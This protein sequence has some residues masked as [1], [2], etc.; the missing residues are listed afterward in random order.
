MHL[1][2]SSRINRIYVVVL[3]CFALFMVSQYF[4]GSQKPRWFQQKSTTINTKDEISYC[5]S[6]SGTSNIAIAVKT[7]A[8]EAASKIP[9][10]MLTSL[11]CA[12]DVMI[13]SDLE[14]TIAGFHLHDALADIPLSAMRGNPDFDFYWKLK[15]ANR[16]GQIENMLKGVRDPRM[17][18]ELAAWT[19][20]KYKFLHVLEKLYAEY[21]NKDWYLLM[22]ADTYVVWPNLVTWLQQLPD[23]TSNK[24]YLGN[25][26]RVK[27]MYFA[28]GGSG[29]LI[30]RAAMYEFAVTNNGTASRWDEAMYD[31]CC[32]DYVVGI[33]LKNSGTLLSPSGP[34]LNGEKPVTLPFGPN[35]WCQPVV[36]MHHVQPSEMT[37]L[38]N[39]ETSRGQH[40]VSHNK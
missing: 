40:Q 39:F 38:A 10:L 16:Y 32:G 22:D 25:A 8:T 28:H 20:D 31:E 5:D 1:N 11:Q 29:I 18:H 12:K 26:A 23:P 19:L 21:P 14:Q 24:L 27:D 34:T 33:E 15:R 13:F 6:I 3:L 17:T 7:G 35:L 9:T 36:T 37:Q 2:N 30:S 4:K